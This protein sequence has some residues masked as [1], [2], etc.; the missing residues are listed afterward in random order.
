MAEVQIT[1]VA[2]NR[3]LVVSQP[4]VVPL[5]IVVGDVLPQDDIEM[6]ARQRNDSSPHFTAN[7]SDEPF[8]EGV[9][10]WGV[11]RQ[12]LRLATNTSEAGANLGGEQR[13]AV[14]DNGFHTFQ[15][16]RV[17]IGEGASHVQHPGAISMIRNSDKSDLS[18]S[19]LD[20]IECM[21]PLCPSVAVGHFEGREVE[22]SKMWPVRFEKSLPIIGLYTLWGRRDAMSSQHV[23]DGSISNGDSQLGQTIPNGIL[24]PRRVV[25]GHLHDERFGFGIEARTSGTFRRVGGG[26][27]LTMPALKGVDGDNEFLGF[28]NTAIESACER[29]ETTPFIV[30]RPDPFADQ[31]FEDAGLFI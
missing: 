18:G 13:I 20:G 15:E 29:C 5:M 31:T 3:D 8:D 7:S 1:V 27:E 4:L 23:G 17:G 30:G 19:N 12:Y 22:R 21:V 26:D 6:V 25:I 28:K 10:V 11:R 16:T 9:Q 2:W 24:A 14:H